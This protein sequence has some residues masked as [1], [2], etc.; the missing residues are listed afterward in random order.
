MERLE[1]DETGRVRQIIEETPWLYR[2]LLTVREVMPPDGCIAAGAIRDSVWNSLTGNTSSSPTR[3]IDVV[4]HEPASPASRDREYER[5]LTARMPNL[6]WEVTN[7]ANIHEWHAR[8]QRLTVE[9]HRDVTE[10]IAT[11]PET[12]TAVA[13]RISR[14]GKIEIVAPLGL[15][16][17][18]SLKL[19][20]N[21]VLVTREVFVSRTKSKRWLERWPLLQVVPSD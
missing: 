14:Q 2:A 18:L 10:G 13:A 4:Y 6:R 9:P 3:D 12:A 1:E 21:P 20:H 7:Q 11:W 5:K 15:G 17:L 19:R 16:D 8:A